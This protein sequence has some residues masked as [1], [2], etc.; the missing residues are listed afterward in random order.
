M[1]RAIIIHGTESNPDQHWFPWLK[2]ELEKLKIEVI[3]PKFPTPKGQNFDNW[4]SVMQPHIRK[5]DRDTI[6]IGH[7]VG[8]AFLLGIVEKFNLKPKALFSVA[9]FVG[10][11]W[12]EKYDPL[13]ETFTQRNFNWEK[14]EKSFGKVFVYQSEDDPYLPMEKSYD[15]AYKLNGEQKNLNKLGH[16]NQKK[17]E[18]LLKDIKSIL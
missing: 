6:L 10:S 1:T 16:I 18:E 17:F 3:V 13:C 15:L 12:D 2:K 9:G 8:V 5:I 4:M 14:L 11:L 7:S